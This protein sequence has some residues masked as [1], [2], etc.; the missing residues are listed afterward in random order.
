MRVVFRFKSGH[1]VS[2]SGVERIETHKRNGNDLSGYDITFNWWGKRTNQRRKIHYL[3]LD[4]V[5]SISV[6]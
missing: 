3:R 1:K 6:S 4:E 2:V 5:E